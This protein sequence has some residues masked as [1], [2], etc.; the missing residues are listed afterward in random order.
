MANWLLLFENDPL[1][2][3]QM[4]ASGS[5]GAEN[6][7]TTMA[8]YGGSVVAQ[9]GLLG[10][11][12]L[13]VIASFP[14]HEEVAAYCLAVGA[15]GSKVEAIAA[16]TPEAVQAATEIATRAVDKLGAGIG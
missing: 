1:A 6:Q 13:A 15:S 5:A 10:R 2:A 12:D 8:A 4:I 9:W 7:Q 16:L 14:R 3:A 11:Y